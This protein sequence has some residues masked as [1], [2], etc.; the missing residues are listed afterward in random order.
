MKRILGLDLGTTSIGWALVNEAE[1]N[2]EASSIVRLG[3][4]VNPLTVDE[5]SNFEKGKAITTNAD[6]QLRHGARINLQRYKLRRQNLHDCLQKQGWLGTEAMYEEGKASTF[7]TYKLRAKAAEEEISLHEFA[8]VLFMLNKKRG[9]KSNRKANNK[10]DGQLF[11]GMTIAKKLYEEHLTPAEYSLQLLNKGKKFTQGYY[12]SDLNA[13]LERIWNEQKK[14]YPEILTD[15]FKQQLEGKT[16]TNTS[17]IFLG[18]YGIYSADLKGLDRK[19]QPLKW[20]V[21]ALQQEVGKEILAF[22]ISDLKGQLANTSGLLGAISDRSKELYFNK[23]TVGQYLWASLEENPHI[24]IKNKPFYRQDYLDEFEKIWETQAAFHKQLTPELKQEIRDI[25][26]FYQRPLKSKKSLISVCELEQRKVKATIDG[27][28]KEI[29][30]GPKVAPKSSPVFQEFRIWQNLNNVLLIDNDTNEKRPLDEDERSLLYEELSI[31][32]KL[33]KTEALKILNKKGKQWDLNYKELEGN[34]TQAIL[35]DCYNRIITLTG[36]EECDFKKIKASEIRHYVSTIFKNLGFSTEILDFDPSLKKHELEKQPMYQLWHL[37]YSYE[38]DN[39]RTGNEALLRK[40]ETTFG[41]PEEYA[42]V[43]CD[44]VFEDDYSNLSVKAMR[45]ILPYLQAGNDYSQACADAGYNHSRRSLTKDELEEKVY[46]DK[47]ELLPKNSLRNPVVEKILNQMINVI[48]TIVAEYGKLDEIRIEMARELK[49]SA[50][51]REKTTRAISQANIENQRIRDILE[52][53]FALSYIS[54]NDII[55][56]KLYEE[57]EAN[58]FK[59]LYSG[60]YIPKEKLFSKDFDIEHII[61]KARLFDDSFSNKTLEARNINIAKS[62][63]TAFDFVKGEYGDEGAEVYKKKL[64]MLLSKDVIS[65]A[66]YNKLLMSEADIPSEFIA[67]DLRNTQ[68]IAKKAYEILSELVRT[69]TPTTGEITNRLREDWQLVD[70]MKE[71][72]FEKYQKLGLAEVVEDRDG[73]KIKRIKDWTK[74]NDHRHHA[75]DALTIAFTKPAFIQYLNNLNARSNKSS[76]IYA[77]ENKELHRDDNKLKFNAPIP[78]NEFRVAAKQHLSSILI[79]IKAK[80]KVMTQNVNKIK[81][82]QGVVR[83][84]QLTPRGQLHNDTIY[85]TKKR[86]IIKKVK[87]GAALDELT[88][89]KISSQAIREALLKRLSEYNGDAKKAFTGKN[90]LEKNPIYLN[91]GRTKTVP[92]LVKTVEWESFHP[93]RKLIDKDLNVDKVVDKCIRNIL[94]TRLEEFNGDAKKAFS[95]LEEN[96]IYLDQTKKIALKRVSIEGVLSAIPLHT[97]KNQAGK[98]ITGKDGKPVLGNYVQTSN[99]HHIAFYY[100]EDSNL[101]D[102][103]VSF[104]EAAERKSQGIPVIDKDYNR[105]KGW[106]F[107]FTMKQNE[108]FVFPNEA[109]GFIPS[110]VDLTDEANYGIISPNLYRVQ[111]MSRIEKGTSVSRDYWFRHH[112]ETILNDDSRLKNSAF[113][114]INSLKPLEGIIKVRINSIGKIV[115]VGEYD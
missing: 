114:R 8:R 51:E 100:D 84:I 11:D 16:K 32:A 110:E 43:L 103:A 30:I 9:Y 55:K 14:Y 83:K 31:K 60:T 26:I 57:L 86:P 99:N 95:N 58:G 3:V 5:K 36:H 109:T 20:R 104:F 15:E 54:R 112:L 37:L 19:L 61:P 27:K 53:E 72:N 69:V 98:P 18:K 34:R 101:Q 45:N 77:I 94:K 90:T 2:N 44:V 74:R 71:L 75:M 66:K 7:E 38:S 106:R 35:F 6:R 70:V 88:I 62:N 67:R 113:K 40:L 33:S 25:I 17:K 97:L 24:S 63:K 115:A 105:D 49:S 81:T 29:T 21:E 59:T 107:L 68:Y 111:K 10:E 87:V 65:K 96:P 1:N 89:N 73:R 93:T 52:K 39:S 50:A 28:E 47:L 4:R 108:Y 48:N 64:D 56:Y 41:F 78:I 22:V 46:K 91:A 92:S 76:S 85:G 80:N 102:N 42:T 13:E 82:K 23:Q 12:R 79:S